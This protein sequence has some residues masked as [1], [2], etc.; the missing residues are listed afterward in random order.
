MSNEEMASEVIKDITK[1]L[2]CVNCKLN[3]VQLIS[4]RH[5]SPAVFHPSFLHSLFSD[6]LCSLVFAKKA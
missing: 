3:C 4:L 6:K 1:V 5:S 2:L